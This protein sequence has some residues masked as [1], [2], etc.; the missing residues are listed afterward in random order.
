VAAG[1]TD[2]FGMRAWAWRVPP[3]AAVAAGVLW[4]LILTEPSGFCSF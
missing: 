4:F 3:S 2:V 1:R